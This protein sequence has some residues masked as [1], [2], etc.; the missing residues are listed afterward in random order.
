[1]NSA[2]FHARFQLKPVLS[3]RPLFGKNMKQAAVLIPMVERNNQLNIVFTQR[4][5]HLKHHPGQISFPGGRIEMADSSPQA[6]ALRE[7]AEEIGIDAERINIIGRL[8]Q[9]HTT[10]NYMVQPFVGFVDADYSIT[11]DENEVSDVFEVPIKH[12]LQR[13]NR[14]QLRVQKSRRHY[15]VHFMPWHDKMIW[16]VTAVMLNDLIKQIQ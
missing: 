3:T 5:L 2:D 6:A 15:N 14:H 9:Y 4:A 16:G 11:I 10:S 7:T 13:E 1:M 8:N 12:F